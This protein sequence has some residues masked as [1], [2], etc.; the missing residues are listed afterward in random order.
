MENPHPDLAPA[1][2]LVLSRGQWEPYHTK[3]E[4]QATIDRFYDWIEGMAQNGKMRKGSRLKVEGKV[5]SKNGVITDGPFGEA[6]EVIG[7]YW[8]IIASSLEE[9]AQLLSGNPCLE[10]GLV[11]ELRPLDPEVATAFNITNETPAEF[12][13]SQ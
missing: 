13:D 5:V 11:F 12:I 4:I 9:A 10:R 1:E 2:Y 8:T 3:E 6:K 7:G